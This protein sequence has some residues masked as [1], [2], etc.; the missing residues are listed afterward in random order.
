MHAV[1]PSVLCVACAARTGAVAEQ[2]RKLGS[3]KCM[4]FSS[5]GR[6]LA[7]GGEDGSI[8]VLEWPSLTKRADLRW[9]AHS[10]SL[11]RTSYNRVPMSYSGLPEWPVVRPH[12][13]EA[14]AP[15]RRP[16]CSMALVGRRSWRAVLYILQS[17]PSVLFWTMAGVCRGD[18]GLKDS[19]RDVDFSP[20]HHH[21]VLVTTGED[22]SCI[23]WEWQSGEQILRLALPGGT[24]EAA[25]ACPLVA[26][27]PCVTVTGR[28]SISQGCGQPT[29]H[30]LEPSF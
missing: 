2:L 16:P 27:L 5:D 22:G 1:D 4:V 19:V 3:V 26:I 8:Q 21:R 10:A 15:Q 29:T 20:A 9:A 7:L 30:P 11:G 18:R 24:S 14:A 12:A 23:L 6:L 28:Q 17:G 13:L 25:S